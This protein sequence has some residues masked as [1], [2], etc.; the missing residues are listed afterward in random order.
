MSDVDVESMEILTAISGILSA[1]TP[2]A[3]TKLFR[4][5]LDRCG[6]DTFAAGEI[7]L[8]HRARCVFHIIDWPDDWRRYYFASG[9]VNRDPFL[10]A[11]ERYTRPFTWAE[12]R[13]DRTLPRL[14]T[15][16]LDKAAEAGW[17]DGLIVP[18][19]RGGQ[20]VGLISMVARR[21]MITERQK[22]L[23]PP[24]C[25]CFHVRLRGMIA[26]H[27]LPVAPA[28]LTARELDCLPLVSK[29]FS[30]RE[31][32]AELNISVST[33]HEHV[34]NA[35]KRFEAGTRSELVAAAVSLG[36]IHF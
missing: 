15:E 5:I 17:I 1:A 13:A 20:R 29:G 4:G 10:S 3:C 21:S 35:R 8:H 34:E 27:D 2:D 30:D 26:G 19:P 33:A 12:L 31:I 28:G 14:G 24:L 7:D 23:L 36:V 9:L 22:L 25:I 18:I 32:A 11:L 16:A 6:I